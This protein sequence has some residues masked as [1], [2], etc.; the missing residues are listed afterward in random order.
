MRDLVAAVEGDVQRSPGAP[1]AVRGELRQVL[2][3]TVSFV[4]GRR[5]RLLRYVDGS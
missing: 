1:A 2:G 4:L 5:P 3:Q